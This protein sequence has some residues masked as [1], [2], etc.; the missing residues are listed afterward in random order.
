MASV[1]VGLFFRPCRTDDGGIIIGH[2]AKSYR[3][4]CLINNPDRG[5]HIGTR[6]MVNNSAKGFI[7]HCRCRNNAQSG[8]RKQC[9]LS[10]L[11]PFQLLVIHP[12][13]RHVHRLCQTHNF[14]TAAV[15]TSNN[16][17]SQIW[18]RYDQGFDSTPASVNSRR[19]GNHMSAFSARKVLIANSGSNPRSSRYSISLKTSFCASS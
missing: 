5:W 19:L 18:S 7:G 12:D 8:G 13:I 4:S 2:H 17:T 14:S 16:K 15:T 10:H 9:Y 11:I 1:H 3:P 6:I